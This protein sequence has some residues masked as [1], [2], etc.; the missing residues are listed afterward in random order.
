MKMKMMRSGI[1]NHGMND[2]VR[3]LCTFPDNDGFVQSIDR[4]RILALAYLGATIV[5]ATHEDFDLQPGES[6]YHSIPV[7]LPDWIRTEIEANIR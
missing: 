1:I 4:S 6:C 5:I 7:C 3:C 2:N